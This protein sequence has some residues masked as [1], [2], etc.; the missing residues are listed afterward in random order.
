MVAH[1]VTKGIVAFGE[2][3]AVVWAGAEADIYVTS[4]VIKP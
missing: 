2:A 1:H 4:A 3:I